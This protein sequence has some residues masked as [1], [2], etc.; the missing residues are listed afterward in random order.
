VLAGAGPRGADA[1]ALEDQLALLRAF[2]AE[3][4]ALAVHALSSPAA[5]L[6]VPPS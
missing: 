1:A 2:L 4:R 5:P 3:A 6:P